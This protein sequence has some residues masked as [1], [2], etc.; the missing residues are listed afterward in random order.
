MSGLVLVRDSKHRSGPVL[1]FDR[2]EWA[3]F[4]V[5]VKLGKFDLT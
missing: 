1:A 2:Q 5:G 4:L 3:E